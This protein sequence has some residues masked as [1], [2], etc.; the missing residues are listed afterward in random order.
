ME[1][2][3]AAI[4]ACE[5]EVAACVGEMASNAAAQQA[6]TTLTDARGVS[7]P[8]RRLSAAARAQ[9]AYLQGDSAR[10][11]TRE[12]QLRTK[13]VYLRADNTPLRDCGRAAEYGRP[14]PRPACVR[15]A[16]DQLRCVCGVTP[17]VQA[18]QTKLSP[19]EMGAAWPDYQ[20]GVPV[21]RYFTSRPPVLPPLA[22][23]AALVSPIFGRFLD[24]MSAPLA[25]LG[26]LQRESE[27]AT[28]LCRVMPK[29]FNVES[30]R[31]EA[32]L[33]A[34]QRLLGAR[35]EGFSPAPGSTSRSDGGIQVQILDL[36]IMLLLIELKNELS[37]GGSEPTF[38]SLRFAELRLEVPALSALRDADA[39]PALLLEVVGP[40]LRVSA[41]AWT[42]SG[43]V[44]CEPLTPLLHALPLTGQPRQLD[45]LLRA[46][47]AL[48][49]ALG[50]LHEHY[51]HVVARLPPA[52]AAAALPTPAAAAAAAAQGWPALPY[53]LQDGAVF[54]DVEHFS[55]GKLLYEATLVATGARVCIKFAPRAYAADV[56]AA[57]AAAGLAPELLEHRVLPGGTQMVVMELLLP[58]DGWCMLRDTGVRAGG[59]FV[60]AERAAALHAALAALRRAHA[61]SLPC[62]RCAAHGDCR[63]VNVMVRRAHTPGG[64][65]DDDGSGAF[66][67]RFLDFDWA[68]PADAARYPPYMSNA[69]MWPNGS[70]PG[71]LITQGSSNHFK[72]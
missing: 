65:A 6:L 55:P 68:G 49:R 29:S 4:A 72:Y 35:V 2:V 36:L 16:A 10:L 47:S 40:H 56:H 11:G 30:E 12:A 1:S 32:F 38:Q 18:V 67:V 53:P 7:T 43:H 8:R 24:T 5:R 46:L 42:P 51:T 52:A 9:L 44:L 71:A 59:G 58:P 48:R 19:S 50:E 39:C 20:F 13:E 61:L 15:R 28:E 70:T 66:E 27:C 63:D 14:A 25:A 41:L 60:A 64:G 22:I 57:W 31:Q 45:D 37:L 62:G 17:A 26:E 33:D 34:V 54:A 3:E 23:P 21:P 69:V